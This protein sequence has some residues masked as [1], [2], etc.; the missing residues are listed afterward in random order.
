MEIKVGEYD[1]FKDGT[2]VATENQTI[3]FVFVEETDF[4]IRIV[5]KTNSTNNEPNII[6]ENLGSAGAQLNFINFNNSFGIG[7]T[8]P[9]IIGTLN[10][11]ELYLNYMVY[12]LNKGGKSFQYTW[13]LG[14][15][16]KHG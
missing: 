1:V 11:R 12:A 9:I 14:K 13:L 2:I 15:E 8:A 5:F 4:I 16:V 7:N 3:D 6:A 10:D